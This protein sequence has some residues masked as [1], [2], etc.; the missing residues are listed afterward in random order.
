MVL[1]HIY[2][3]QIL[4]KRKNKYALTSKWIKRVRIHLLKKMQD[5]LNLFYDSFNTISTDTT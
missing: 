5:H 2:D 3:G 4:I 1:Y